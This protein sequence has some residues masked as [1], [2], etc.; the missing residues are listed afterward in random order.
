M[1]FQVQR[2]LTFGALHMSIIPRVPNIT[3]GFPLSFV[4]EY[5]YYQTIV[6]YAKQQVDHNAMEV[7]K[8]SCLSVCVTQSV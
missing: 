4:D 5:I 1:K 2:P 8:G 7:V 6:A 3:G